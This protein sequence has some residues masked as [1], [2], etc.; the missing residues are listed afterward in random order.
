MALLRANKEQSTLW[1]G[2][3]LSVPTDAWTEYR[4]LL[5]AHVTEDSDWL[6]I[7]S[8][9]QGFVDIESHLAPSAVVGGRAGFGRRTGV[10]LLHAGGVG[11]MCWREFS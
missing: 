5:A 1:D 10:A 11:S 3:E 6:A 9:F 8:A 2:P 7:A 4:D